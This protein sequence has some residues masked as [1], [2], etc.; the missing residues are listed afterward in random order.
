VQQGILSL[1]TENYEVW[2]LTIIIIQILFEITIFIQMA[3]I[4]LGV[5]VA[6][7]SAEKSITPTPLE[8]YPDLDVF[9]PIRRV[10]ASVLE[11]TIKG[12]RDGRYSQE[13]LHIYLADD[14]PEEH[15]IVKYKALADK[16][17]VTYIHDPTNKKFKAGMLNIALKQGKSDY[18]AFFDFDQVPQ[19]DILN[20]FIEVLYDHD[21]VSFVQAKK[22]FHDLT[23]LAKVWSALLYLQYF[24]IFQRNKEITN[25]VLFAGSTACFRRKAIDQVGG[26]PE[27]TFTEDNGLAVK[28]MLNGLYGKYTSMVGSVGS[29]PY[30]FSEQ[31]SQLWRWSHGASHVLRNTGMPIMK[32]KELK[33]S[34]KID[35][36]GTL[37]I[38]PVVI[39]VYIYSLTFIPLILSGVDSKRVSI[40][41]F[42]S[43][44][45]IP[46]ITALTYAVIAVVAVWLS[47]LDET[48]EFK[49]RHLPGF[50][51]I[52]LSS[53]VLTFSSGI[54]G[55]F[56]KL[57]P[58]SNRGKW[59]RE[60]R[61]LQISI[62]SFIIGLI[63]EYFA[64]RWLLIDGYL[65]AILLIIIGFTLFSS[66]PI[67][68]YYL[69]FDS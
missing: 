65:S 27:D 41:N 40:G 33:V 34:Q 11:Q 10:D 8:K 4:I 49:F 42:S 55:I 31:I 5:T 38:A 15:L 26:I 28:L 68:L 23:N 20:H 56:G 60:I 7:N 12:L 1:I 17:G 69:R 62:A 13:H 30:G 19:R 18:V 46:I 35:I 57:G 67:S 21:D 9:I 47:R 37:G 54:T 2:Q 43:L 63:L 48:S 29:V 32:S 53:N 50:L 22:T 59:T 39:L 3:F 36:I 24:E 14:T 45:L 58:S 64:I 61:I 66:L 16:Y 51:I 6:I 25:T 44:A 52:A